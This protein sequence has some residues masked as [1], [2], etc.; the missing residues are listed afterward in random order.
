MRTARACV[1]VGVAVAVPGCTSPT[2]TTSPPS[3]ATDVPPPSLSTTS[4]SPVRAG[5]TAPSPTTAIPASAGVSAP[6]TAS[7][8]AT[9]VARTHE[10][11]VPDE[12]FTEGAPVTVA[13]GAGGYLT[14]V[15]ARRSPSADG[16]GE[17][18]FFWHNRTFLGWD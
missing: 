9:Q 7:Q 3:S 6:P 10:T 15:P 8:I 14:A 5:T 18:V 12:T 16:H 11:E 17:L 13:D 4:T 2:H 1:A